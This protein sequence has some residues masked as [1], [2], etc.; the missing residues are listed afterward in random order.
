M[1]ELKGE[2]GKSKIIIE[3]GEGSKATIIENISAKGDRNETVKIIAKPNSQ[4][5]FGSVQKIPYGEN[6]VVRNAVVEDNANVEWLEIVTGSSITKSENYS[7]LV[8]EGAKTSMFTVFFGH[9]KQQFD[10]LNKCTHIG[11]NTE[12]LIL[13]SGALQD[14]AKAKQ[15]GFAKIEKK[16]YNA[17]AHQKA[18]TLLL[19]EGTRA[20]PIPKLEIDNNDV[21]ATHEASVG[22]IEEEKIF[23]LMSRGIDKQEAKKLYVE[24]F[25][26]QYTSKISVPELRQDVETIVAK[27]MK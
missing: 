21:A 10:F 22:Q 18:K 20:L 17:T 26:E 16:A 24:G 7:E 6:I 13:S 2:S 19:D 15:E 11:R 23:Y 3:A 25:F 12:S 8:G 27:R 1:I 9:G 5:M 14:T 4:I